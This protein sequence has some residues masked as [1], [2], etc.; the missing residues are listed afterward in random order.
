MIAPKDHSSSSSLGTLLTV[1]NLPV[2][3]YTSQSVSALL[4]MDVQNI[5][6]TTPTIEIYVEV[7]VKYAELR[8]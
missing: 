6:A 7:L 4:E 3:A 8:L 1:A 2:A 5:I